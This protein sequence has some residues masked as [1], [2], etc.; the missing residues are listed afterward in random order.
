[1]SHSNSK[2]FRQLSCGGICLIAL[3]ILTAKANTSEATAATPQ[4]SGNL[5]FDYPML[6][7]QS[8]NSM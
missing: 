7:R 8:S 5:E 3:L 6:R 4:A 2:M 1:M